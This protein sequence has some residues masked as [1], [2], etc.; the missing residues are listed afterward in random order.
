M[1]VV[2]KA[3]DIRL[4]RFV[5][6][7]F[8]PEQLAG[9]SQAFE[10]F[11]RE[12]RAASALNHPNICTIYD[13]AEEAGKTFI[14]M[15]YLDGRTLRHAIGGRAIEPEQVLGLA[16]DIA[17]GLEAAHKRGII[18]RDIKP[19]NVFVVG[20]THAKI[21]DFGLAKYSVGLGTTDVVTD[22]QHQDLT[23]SGAVLGT[24]AYMSP[25][26]LVSKEL[27]TRTDLFSLGVTLY[28][29]A[30]GKHPFP[31]ASSALVVNAILNQAPV[32]A[33]ELNPLLPARLEDIIGK[34][35]EKDRE[36]RYQHASEISVDLQ[37]IKRDRTSQPAT[38]GGQNG[39]RINESH[40]CSSRGR[41]F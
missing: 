12:A 1:G 9:D 40:D 2:Y 29:M 19:A 37:R 18:H 33:A 41:A 25:E 26:Q 4:H 6:L 35:L 15:E 36:F 31:G 24:V 13:I 22:L 21:L 17:D 7:K 11:R 10:R 23:V 27:D 20:R 32:P 5:A 8:L 3:E 38:N 39:R 14:V 16:I 30:T 28:E 34:A